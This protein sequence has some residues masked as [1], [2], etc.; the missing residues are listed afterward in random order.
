MG[1]DANGA[2]WLLDRARAGV[3]FDRTLMIGRQNFFVGRKEWRRLLARAQQPMSEAWSSLECFH[4]AHAEPF[5]QAL[6]AKTVNSMDATDYEGADTI[7]DLN[8]PVPLDWRAR[9][10]VVFDGGSLEHVFQF[11][12]ALLNCLQLVKTGG[13]FIAYTPANNYFGHGFYQFSPELW[14]RALSKESGFQ[15]DKLVAVE[16][17]WRVRMFEIS[18]PAQIGSRI[19]IVNHAYVLLFLCARKIGPTPE[20]FGPVMQS[21]YAATWDQSRNAPPSNAPQK[22]N[23]QRRLLETAPGLAR[24]LERAHYRWFNSRLSFRNHAAFSPCQPRF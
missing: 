22:P 5:F 7:H 19:S 14:W 6:G 3:K 21:D 12:T 1:I 2:A 11:P 20:S 13:H 18:D 17:G 10:D 24:F 9:Y 4:G 8:Q 16:F 15:I 23:W